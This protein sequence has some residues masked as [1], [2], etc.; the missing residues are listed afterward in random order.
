MIHKY[1]DYRR[2]LPWIAAFLIFFLP[3]QVTL[4][5]VP[6]NNGVP[7]VQANEHNTSTL[8]NENMISLNMDAR[9]MRLVNYRK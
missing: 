1:F 3:S 4:K 9:F 2:R 8:P 7:L 6:E 5:K